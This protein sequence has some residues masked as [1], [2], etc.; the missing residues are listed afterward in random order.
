VN[1]SSG[2]IAFSIIGH[3]NDLVPGI[4]LLALAF[5]HYNSSPGGTVSLDTITLRPHTFLN[6]VYGYYVIGIPKVVVAAA[7]T[8]PDMIVQPDTLVF[9]T[10]AGYPNPDY[11]QFS[12]QSSGAAFNW[13]LTSPS[14]V[15]VDF[16]SGVSGQIVN[17]TPDIVGLSVGVYYGDI[18]ISSI[19]ALGSPKKVVVKLTLRQQFLSLDANCDGAFNIADIVVQINY[20]FKGGKV[21]NPC[22]GEWSKG[23]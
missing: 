21:C 5:F 19:G 2:V 11:Q 10:L 6:Y 23:K 17:V 13:T 7:S 20:L 15:N 3:E 9:E 14:W 4:N 12:I 16:Q 18:I 22:T 8:F 1:G